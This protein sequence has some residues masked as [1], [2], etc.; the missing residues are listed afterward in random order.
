MSLEAVMDAVALRLASQLASA[1]DTSTPGLRA[2]YSA[3][4]TSQ[5]AAIIPRSIDDWP[6]AIVWAAGGE[7]TAGNGPEPILHRLEVRI[8]CGATDAAFAYQTLV[9]F[10]QRCRVLFRTDLHAS[11]ANVS[12]LLMTG[13]DAP[14]LDEAHGKPFLVLPIYLEALEL[15]SVNTYSVDP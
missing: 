7:L 10:V 4:S 9:P 1:S 3:A 6:V 5:G 14:E 12:R 2:A 8:W 15:A 11:L 13:Y